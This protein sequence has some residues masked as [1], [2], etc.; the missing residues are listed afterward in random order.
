MGQGMA[1]EENRPAGTAAVEVPVYGMTCG[2]CA[3]G[4]DATLSQLPGVD[5][6]TVD[7]AGSRVA[8]RGAP[9]AV[10]ETRVRSEIEQLGYQLTPATPDG[11]R[12]IRWWP[13]VLIV[14]GVVA[15]FV[16]GALVFQT[17]SERYFGAGALQ[18]LNE[19]FARPSALVLGLALAF[20]LIVGFAPSTLAMAPAVV[21]YVGGARAS[22]PARALRLS[23]A[24]V[25]GMVIVD[26]AL[27]AVFALA[28]AGAL[29]VLGAQ[30]PLWYV[31][32]SVVLVA[33]ALLNLGLWRPRLPSLAPSARFRS[34]AAGGFALGVPFGLLTCPA[35][36][37]L[38]L[39]IALG[40]AATA[41]PV[42]G[43]ALLG[44]FALGRGIP[45]VV[46]ATSG[47]SLTTLHAGARWLRWLKWALGLMLLLAAGFFFRE[48]L[49]IGGFGAL[50]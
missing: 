27:G 21:G 47:A 5:E 43:A 11:G 30:L 23:A 33:L 37:P 20:G 22:S 25:A 41:N 12:R 15:A 16:V 36:T 31:L 42:Y 3:A 2:S 34:S 10:V 6:V 26:M 39:P 8:V 35:C 9:G 4:I 45:L 19:T 13:P 49:M 32:V 50:L 44:A 38:L 14:A 18:Q 7:L 48:F 40:A 17:A 24:F 28:G 1:S 29:R 46:L